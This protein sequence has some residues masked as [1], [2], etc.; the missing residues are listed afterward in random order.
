M[1]SYLNSIASVVNSHAVPRLLRLNGMSVKEPPRWTPGTVGSV[2]LTVVIQFVSEMAKAGM[3]IFPD[4][5]TE[6]DLRGRA[7]LPLLTE[8]QVAERGQ[9]SAKNLAAAMLNAQSAGQDVASVDAQ[10][11]GTA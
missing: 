6:N 5:E 10:G 3:E 8:E 7:G 11:T 9:R 4:M 2:D 1:E